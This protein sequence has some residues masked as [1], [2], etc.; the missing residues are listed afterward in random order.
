M[1][2]KTGAHNEQLAHTN[3]HTPN[4]APATMSRFAAKAAKQCCSKRNFTLGLSP[5]H[6]VVELE[7]T[8]CTPAVAFPS[9]FVYAGASARR[10]F[11][12]CDHSPVHG[13]CCRADCCCLL[14]KKTRRP[15]MRSRSRSRRSRQILVGAGAFRRPEPEP[16]PPKRF[17]R[18][19]SRSRSRQKRGGSGSEKG[20]NCGKKKKRKRN[21]KKQPNK[22]FA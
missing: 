4:A 3:I 12:S 2:K 6:F 7:P 20:Y 18:S 17:A 19:R 9:P 13:S 15:G 10:N 14:L 5:T 16:E 22:E 11:L 21:N 1:V 8:V